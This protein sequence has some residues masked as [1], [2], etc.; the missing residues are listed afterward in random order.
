[1]VSETYEDVMAEVNE[2]V[3][4]RPPMP[5]DLA[6]GD[7]SE[8][9]I[10]VLKERYLDKN[11]EGEIIETPDELVWRVAFI[12]ASAEA[13]FGASIEE[14]TETAKSFYKLM[15]SRKFLPNSPT[16][17]NAGKNNGLQYS[18]CFVLPVPDSLEGIFDAIKYQAIIHQSGGGTGFSFSRLRQRGSMVKR[19]RGVAS[20]PISF[21]RVFNEATQQIKQGGTRRG[22]NMGILRVDHPDVRE[23]ITCKL[24]GGLANFN[25]S[26]AATDKFMKALAKG[27]KYDLVE[28]HSGEVI[29]Q[30]DA[31]EIFDLICDC[32]WRSG[33]PGMIFID[34]VNAGPANPVPSLGPVESTNPCG[35]QPLYPFDACNLG[36]IFLNYFVK[37]EKGK[38]QV[39]W[40]ELKKTAGEAVRFLDDV[41]EINPYPLKQVWDTVRSIRRVGLGIGGWADMLY[42]LGVP[43][44]SEEALKLA[45]KVMKTINDAAHE[46]SQELAKVRGAFPLFKESIYKDGEPMRNAAI[47]TI[48]PT[49]TIGIIANTSGGCEPVFA[50]AYKHMVKD[51]SLNREMFFSDPAFTEVA[52][53]EGFWSEELMSR[54]AETGSVHGVAEVPEE[55]QK[56]LV[57][58]HEISPEWHVRM[59]AAW[60]KNLDNAVS[61]TIN[62]PNEAVVD[63]VAK[64]YLSAYELGCMGI[65]IYRD[66]CKEWQVLNV[67]T[68]KEEKKVEGVIEAAEMR[69]R[70][71]KLQGNTYKVQTPVG[72]AFVVINADESGNPFEV[73][74]NVGKAGSHVMADAEAMGRLIS[75]SLRVPS[76]YPAKAVA[77]AIVDQLSG[78]GGA[79]SV[80]FGNNRVR[81]LAD[82]VAKVL[83]EY[84]RLDGN[85]SENVIEEE[86]ELLATQQELPLR[87]KRGDLCPE[88]GQA[89][90]VLE[91]GCQK[92]YSCGASKC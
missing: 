2:K 12:I 35:E 11:S 1:M 54:V 52:K 59:Q 83:R 32:A 30:E 49:G 78:I 61:K 38:Q 72:T 70:P 37:E 58:A 79:D 36:S 31:R 8:Q 92:C 53:R 85:M 17:M 67:G 86:P 75:L 22:A 56:I 88:C 68:K 63:D 57:T 25:I 7:W 81:S 21:M 47:T 4:K 48:A 34:R 13:R 15:G 66:G 64:A 23:F 51:E 24:D 16:L 42:L 55:W 27:E 41:I 87:V 71:S 9:G 26:V 43:Y 14:I 20:G 91:E 45:E 69:I 60:Q 10:K 74:I 28:P 18:G 33:D 84:V 65:T 82:G 44:N 39:D 40:E 6:P 5:K 77:E 46:S 19:S 76:T 29:G 3:G 50:L 90:L 89:S 80:G 62:L 73:F